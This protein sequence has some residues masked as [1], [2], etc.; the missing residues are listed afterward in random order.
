MRFATKCSWR[1]RALR[2]TPAPWARSS[3]PFRE[4][5]RHSCGRHTRCGVPEMIRR[6]QRAAEWASRLRPPWSRK[7]PNSNCV[8]QLFNK[9]RA[10]GTSLFCPAKQLFFNLL[11][12][13][14]Q[15]FVALT[16][17]CQLAVHQFE[18]A[19]LDLA[20]GNAA[21]K[22][23]THFQTL[24][25]AGKSGI[26]IKYRS[27]V[28]VLGFARLLRVGPDPHDGPAQFFARQPHG[29]GVVVTFG[30]LGH[31]YPAAWPRDPQPGPRAI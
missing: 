12:V 1:Q 3:P 4:H 16:R 26:D 23:L 8:T 20:P 27:R 31:R 9:W 30:H 15:R 29:N 18:Q 28:G 6:R 5:A 10:D 24:L 11:G 22:F 13:G 7:R 2:K 14:H 17:F 19:L 25:L 21:G